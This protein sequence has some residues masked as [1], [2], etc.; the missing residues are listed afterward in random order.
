[1]D[2]NL[3]QQLNSL[4]AIKQAPAS[5]S[6]EAFST[7][8]ACLY[9]DKDDKKET[10]LD[11][12]KRVARTAANIYRNTTLNCN[13][14][15]EDFLHVISSNWLGLS[16][17]I[18]ANLGTPAASLPISCFVISVND[19]INGIFDSLHEASM[20]TKAGG[21]VGIDLTSIRPQGQSIA[22]GGNS[23]GAKPWATIFDIASGIVSQAGVRRGQFS[24]N[25][26][27]ESPDLWDFLLAKDHSKGDPRKHIHS[28]I[29]VN[30]TDSFMD[31]LYSNNTNAINIW[32]AVLRTRLI[33]GSPYLH[34]IDNA[35][36]GLVQCMKDLG[37]KITST[38]ICVEISSCSTPDHTMV[39]CLASEN[40]YLYDAWKHWKGKLDKNLHEIGIL[41]LD[42]VMQI[43]INETADIKRYPK[44]ERAREYAL[45]GR[46]LGLGVFGY[47]AYLMSKNWAF[48]SE[49][50]ANF[51][52]EFFKQQYIDCNN[53]SFYLAK[54]LQPAPWAN[55][56]RNIQ[57]TAIAPTV[58]NSVV[59]DG[60]SPGI[61]PLE[62]NYYEAGGASGSFKRKNPVLE[63]ILER[64]GYNTYE[65]WE[66][67]L[68]N[69][70]SVQH[71]DSSILSPQEKNIFKTF[72]EIDQRAIIK[73][74]AQRQ[75]YLEQTQSVNLSF[76][77]DAD[78]EYI[79]DVHLMAQQM[80]LHT[81][82]YLRSESV[83]KKMLRGKEKE[84]KEEI[85]L[86]NNGTSDYFEI[87]E[88]K[89]CIWCEKSIELLQELKCSY[90]KFSRDSENQFVVPMDYITY[91][92]I[93]KNGTF[94]GGYNEL[95]ECLFTGVSQ[96][97]DTENCSSCD[98]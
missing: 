76:D 62:A 59:N 84:K 74:A 63:L 5:M 31:K 51:N 95:R 54:L 56:R 6:L 80:G 44:M 42:A 40:L 68:K 73:M 4:K 46:P 69:A 15:Y 79:S 10:P 66:N 81:L 43:F 67:I 61:E 64:R 3:T 34:F 92:K 24:F 18:A 45:N 9:V 65:I 12:Y 86:F 38:N 72:N 77:L 58:G 7:L 89:G 83:Q 98:G 30:V 75:M 49:E 55:S 39:C 28:N 19:A 33:S 32:N 70:G 41:F 27:I 97:M 16:T 71:L 94:I 17:P 57:L 25:I 90:G 35:N 82:Y 48:D 22:G 91:P 26:D 23:N 87:I 52:G 50:A 20:L 36:R 78:A 2:K 60:I 47:H 14:V 11:M 88:K 29:C 37:K 93:F 85:N 96:K 1:M 53:A 21:G 8:R 13:D